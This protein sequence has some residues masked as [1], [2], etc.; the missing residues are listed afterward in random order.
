MSEAE[1]VNPLSDE[2]WRLNNL[3]FIKDKEG[4][5]V[6][7]TMNWA[8]KL[9]YS[10]MWYLNIIL[11]AR[12]LGMTTFIQIFMLDRC[13]FNENT[14]AGVIAHTLEDAIAFFDDKIKFAYDNL[15]EEIKGAAGGLLQTNNSRELKFGNGSKIRVGTSMRSGTLQYLHVSEF[16][17]ICA[18]FPKKAT[19][20]ITG[21]LNTVAAG[22]FVFIESTAEGR[23]GRFYDM[24]QTAMAAVDTL[25]S[26]MDYKFFFFPWF[27][28]PDYK[29]DGAPVPAPTELAEYFAELEAEH[30]IALTQSQRNWYIKK[31]AEQ[32]EDMKQEYP[33][34]PEEAFAKMLKGAIF[35]EQIRTMR[36][37]KR[38]C[39]LP[40]VRG[41]PVNTFWD[42]GHNDT[43]AIW[44]HQRVGAWDHFIRYYSHRLVDM[45]HY[46]E[47]LDI[48]G[49]PVGALYSS[50][51]EGIE[52]RGYQWGTMYLP[53]DGKTK[54]IEAVAGSSQQI[55]KD[56]G[57]R[58][59]VVPRTKAKVTSIQKTRKKFS[60]ARIDELA[61][62]DGLKALEGYQWTWD[63]QHLTYRKVPA[64]NWAGHGSDAFQTWGD[65]YKGE[66]SGFAAQLATVDGAADR[67]YARG[68][69]AVNPITNPDYSHIV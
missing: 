31:S 18:Q 20:V 2:R 43:N 23:Q 46:I 45:T 5:K 33:A 49:M 56:A 63:E 42:L 36:K 62:D 30:D 1:Q 8:Q 55:L 7:F 17:K 60:Q 21:S 40:H 39:E 58:A 67:K 13:L 14:N 26:K 29:L 65:G 48:L 12:Q 51:I 10:G 53:H 54:H 68:R 37:E 44:F 47:V 59:K 19:E 28:H 32:D 52:P 16:G 9:L 6:R 27:K 50:A 35:A 41:V 69:E 15:P 25:L 11:K 34:T 38:I 3:Y 64:P 22:Q 4:Q 24:C 61:C 66:G 57:Y